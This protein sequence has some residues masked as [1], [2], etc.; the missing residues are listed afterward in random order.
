MNTK[1]KSRSAALWIVAALIVLSLLLLIP[2]IASGADEEAP[3]RMESGASVRI[4]SPTGLRFT[5]SLSASEYAKVV[6]AETM[7]YQDGYEVGMLIVPSEFLAAYRGQEEIEDVIDYFLNQGKNYI[8]LGF[9]PDQL[10]LNET[11]GRYEFNGAIT[12]ILEQNLTRDFSAL[13]YVEQNGARTYAAEDS[14]ARD[15]T[16]VATKAIESGTYNATVMDSLATTYGLTYKTVNVTMPTAVGGKTETVNIVGANVTF[17]DVNAV[18]DAKLGYRVSAFLDGETPATE[19]THGAT[20]TAASIAVDVNFTYLD[21]TKESIEAVYGSGLQGTPKAQDA[22]LARLN[23]AGD[24]KNLTAD[25]CVAY[26]YKTVG[27]TPSLVFNADGSATASSSTN[28]YV[29]VLMNTPDLTDKGWTAE[30]KVATETITTWQTY[31]I[32]VRYGTDNDWLLLGGRMNNKNVLRGQRIVNGAYPASSEGS[33]VISDVNLNATFALQNFADASYVKVKVAYNDG[34]YYFYL[35][36]QIMDIMTATDLGVATYGAPAELGFGWG[37][38]DFTT[39]TPSLTFSDWSIAVEGDGAWT[40][41]TETEDDFMV[42]IGRMNGMELTNPATGAY[43]L[44]KKTAGTGSSINGGFTLLR[45]LSGKNWTISTEVNVADIYKWET[46]GFVLRYADGTTMTFGTRPCHNTD[47]S[48][49]RLFRWVNNDTGYTYTELYA[50]ADPITVAAIADQTTLPLTLTYYGGK[51]YF[52]MNGVLNGVWTAEEFGVAGY[53]VPVEAGLGGMIQDTPKGNSVRFTNC[54]ATAGETVAEPTVSSYVGVAKG[55]WWIDNGDGTYTLKKI[56]G[57]ASEGGK[58]LRDDLSGKNWTMEVK[59]N[60]A[61]LTDWSTYGFSLRFADGSCFIVG[62]RRCVTEG[63]K[64]F[65]ISS[66]SG[67]YDNG[68]TINS[69]TA[70]A[71]TINSTYASA[72]TLDLKLTY[73][74]GEVLFLHQRLSLPR[75]RA[76]RAEDAYDGSCSGRLRRKGRRRDDERGDAGRFRLPCLYR[77]RER[78]CDARQADDRRYGEPLGVRTGRQPHL[79]GDGA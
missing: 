45:G 47:K 20:Y 79:Y 56:N 6:D 34:N 22:T 58:F 31:G 64:W 14:D 35:N 51:Y 7:T 43:T 52:S 73:Y 71:D 16:D 68:A 25:L 13:A 2:I 5:A 10:I 74:N 38:D 55:G 30:V 67:G 77:G 50:N 48:Q 3:V 46:Y 21:G 66:V 33:G 36:D 54:T 65:R 53:G 17:A 40:A 18:L 59:Y 69:V 75:H 24:F 23:Y 78:L 42:L 72:T 60:V 37:I 70:F 27:H 44:T 12:N 19:I 41:P 28:N 11:S 15:I 4:T 8:N 63:V 9:N 49:M 1:A 57:T 61:D 62:A 32:A 76:Y 29:G 26:T 39:K